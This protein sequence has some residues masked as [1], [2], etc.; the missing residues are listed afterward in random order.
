MSF[1]KTR[2][3]CFTVVT[4]QCYKYVYHK[5]TKIILLS[6]LLIEKQFDSKFE[7]TDNLSGRDVDTG[8]FQQIM[9]ILNLLLKKQIK[10]VGEI[11][12]LEMF[13]K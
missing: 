10:S 1:I 9:Q 2:L 6:S 12:T 11:L 3:K 4:F 5:E 13:N 7:S 8:N